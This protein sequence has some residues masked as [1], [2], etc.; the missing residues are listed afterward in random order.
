MF[1]FQFVFRY[2]ERNYVDANVGIL[3]RLGLVMSLE[4]YGTQQNACADA[5]SPLSN[6]AQANLFSTLRTA[7]SK[8]DNNKF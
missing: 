5:L 8:Y 3:P 2:I 7:A 1:F 4:G 6:N